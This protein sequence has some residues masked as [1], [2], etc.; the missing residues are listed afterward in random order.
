MSGTIKKDFSPEAGRG[1]EQALRGKGSDEKKQAFGCQLY[2]NAE[3]VFTA[4]S[5]FFTIDAALLVISSIC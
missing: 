3:Q 1:L 5:I 2:R 4:A